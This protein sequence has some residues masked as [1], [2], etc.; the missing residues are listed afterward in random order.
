[1]QE[2]EEPTK[3]KVVQEETRSRIIQRVAGVSLTIGLFV[4]LTEKGQEVPYRL[5]ALLVM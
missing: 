3:S 4:F 2:T 5:Q 1:M